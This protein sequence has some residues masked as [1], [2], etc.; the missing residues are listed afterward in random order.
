[1]TDRESHAH[2]YAQTQTHARTRTHKIKACYKSV[3]LNL[4]IFGQQTERFL[5]EGSRRFLSSICSKS[6]HANSD[7]YDRM[8]VVMMMII[9]V[10][11]ARVKTKLI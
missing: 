1:M 9:Y 4:Y 7:E 2:T 8:M 11:A 5:T 6:L 3:Y 10:A